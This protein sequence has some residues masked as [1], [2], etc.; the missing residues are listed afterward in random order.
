[1]AVVME[2]RWAGITSEQYDEAR[3]RVEWETKTPDG[4]IFHVAWFSEGGIRVVDVWES[5]VA[6]DRFAEER[7]MPVVKGELGFPG[8]PDVQ[9]FPAHRIFDAMH[10]EARS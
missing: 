4:A 10:D 7:L 3:D 6:F 8:E 9:F 1:M 5:Q 2:M